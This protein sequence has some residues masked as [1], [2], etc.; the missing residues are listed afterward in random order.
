MVAPQMPGVHLL[1]ALASTLR[2]NRVFWLV[3]SNHRARSVI[4]ILE[5]V[6]RLPVGSQDLVTNLVVFF[7]SPMAQDVPQMQLIVTQ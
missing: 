6:E 7:S 1:M 5:G 4:D 3:R 2:D